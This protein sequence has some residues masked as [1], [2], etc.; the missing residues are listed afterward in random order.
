MGNFRRGTFP[1]PLS[2]EVNLKSY[3]HRKSLEPPSRL[4]TSNPEYRVRKRPVLSSQ[5]FP[6]KL[7]LPGLTRSVN[8]AFPSEYTVRTVCDVSN[9]TRIHTPCRNVPTP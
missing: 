5:L 2:T 7:D 6:G 9:S 4:T 8:G 3:P 1:S